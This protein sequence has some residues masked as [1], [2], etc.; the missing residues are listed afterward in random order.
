MG[1]ASSKRIDDGQTAGAII[2]SEPPPWKHGGLKMFSSELRAT[3][4]GGRPDI[5]E[6]LRDAAECHDH[7]NYKQ[8]ILNMHNIRLVNPGMS[9]CYDDTGYRYKLPFYVLS[10]PTD[11]DGGGRNIIHRILLPSTI[12]VIVWFGLGLVVSE[13]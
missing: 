3:R 10:D 13:G 11:L 12:D 5:W 4:D 7:L 6:A 1:C 2:V 8:G 9:V